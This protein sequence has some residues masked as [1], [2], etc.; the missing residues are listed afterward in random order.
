M[1]TGKRQQCM[2]CGESSAEKLKAQAVETTC[3]SR[4]TSAVTEDLG[5]AGRFVVD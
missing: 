4:E 3:L 5:G 1:T 2:I